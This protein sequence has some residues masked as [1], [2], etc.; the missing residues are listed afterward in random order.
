MSQYW[1][2]QKPCAAAC[3]SFFGQILRLF[4]AVFA[5]VATL[6]ISTVST[7]KVNSL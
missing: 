6:S 1:I 7:F 5:F 2:V 4:V 3:Q